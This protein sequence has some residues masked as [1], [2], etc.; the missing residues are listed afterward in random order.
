MGWSQMTE[1][2][3]TANP[4]KKKDGTFCQ[5]WSHHDCSDRDRRKSRRTNAC[6]ALQA[7]STGA[8]HAPQGTRRG[9]NGNQVGESRE[10]SGGESP[11]STAD[12]REGLP[13]R[14]QR[15]NYTL[16]KES[17]FQSNTKEPLKII[18]GF[19]ELSMSARILTH[20]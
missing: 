9:S 18:L 17:P 12:S 5:P 16:P 2:G 3:S 14:L 13:P 4:P 6:K 11:L 19:C 7:S 20:L 15:L 8:T 1:S 10:P